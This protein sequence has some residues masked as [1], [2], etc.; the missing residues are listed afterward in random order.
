ML[1]LH[2]VG[3]PGMLS[4]WPT[5]ESERARLCTLW[6][7]LAEDVRSA[8]GPG[9]LAVL[10]ELPYT[11]T[12]PLPQPYVKQGYMA[13]MDTALVFFERALY[14]MRCAGLHGPLHD[15]FCQTLESFKSRQLSPSE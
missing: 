9:A 12:Q 3:H 1:D 5:Q 7:A 15:E 4:L 2:P 8:R 13:T 6:T 11:F 14:L 10:G